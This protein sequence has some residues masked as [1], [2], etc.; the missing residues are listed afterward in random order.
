[1]FTKGLEK[2]LWHPGFFQKTNAVAI[3][4]TENC[5][6]VPVFEINWP[7]A[8]FKNCFVSDIEFCEA[9]KTSETRAKKFEADSVKLQNEIIELTLELEKSRKPC[10]TNKEV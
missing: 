8:L 9:L 2:K 3:L 7:L 1:M 5:P 10:E 6:S 4:C